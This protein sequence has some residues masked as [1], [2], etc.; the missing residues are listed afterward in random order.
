MSVFCSYVVLVVMALFIMTT[1]LPALLELRRPKDDSPL[2]IDEDYT[3]DPFDRGNRF[4]SWIDSLDNPQ[5]K[6]VEI[7]KTFP[8]GKKEYTDILIVDGEMNCSVKTILRK[9]VLS[10]ETATIGSDSYVESLLCNGSLTLDE[11]VSVRNWID[12]RGKM[13]SVG[14]NC[15]LGHSCVCKGEM[16]LDDGDCFE[17][18][19]AKAI[20]TCVRTHNLKVAT[21][22]SI[23]GNIISRDKI[24]IEENTV[25]YGDIK[26]YRCVT[27]KSNVIVEGSVFAES[28]IEIGPDCM[29]KGH[30]F[31]QGAVTIQGPTQIGVPNHVKSLVARK[32]IVISSGVV[33]YGNVTCRGGMVKNQQ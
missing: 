27:L 29:I 25:V 7:L 31:S 5:E 16:I 6:S 24:I 22:K 10:R 15:N 21:Q 19:F 14:K 12:S 8:L 26:G 2:K 4:L 28:D 32:E 18:L 1:F 30:V 33:I 3:R 13:L 23:K 20:Y 9:P 17:I 11:R